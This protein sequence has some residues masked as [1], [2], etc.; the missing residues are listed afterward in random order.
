MSVD[1][2]KSVFYLGKIKQSRPS[3]KSFYM[4]LERFS[5]EENL[6][7]FKALSEYL[8]RTEMKK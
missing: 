2:S 8:K 5:E 1:D 4:S 3:Y 7:I 6:C